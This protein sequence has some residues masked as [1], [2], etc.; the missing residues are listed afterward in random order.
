MLSVTANYNSILDA[1][2]QKD[3]PRA[4]PLKSSLLPRLVE[5]PGIMGTD[6]TVIL[7]GKC[8]PKRSPVVTPNEQRGTVNSTKAGRSQLVNKTI[9]R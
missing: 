8:L 1:L 7:S 9:N 3:G 2:S 6:V 5:L 4:E